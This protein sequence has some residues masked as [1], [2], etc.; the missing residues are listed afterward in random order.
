MT[1]EYSE[2]N[3]IS[4]TEKFLSQSVLKSFMESLRALKSCDQVMPLAEN[5]GIT[6]RCIDSVASRATE[7]SLFGW[8]VSD[9]GPNRNANADV[10]SASS[11]SKQLISWNGIDAAGGR[12]RSKHADSWFEDL[13]VLSLLLFK[14]LISAMKSGDLSLEMVET[15]LMYYVKKY[16]LGI[17]RKNRKP[18]SSNSPATSPRLSSAADPS[19]L[20]VISAENDASKFIT[21]DS[22]EGSVKLRFG[23]MG[24]VA[25]QS[26]G[27]GIV[28]NI[29]AM[30]RCSE[31]RLHPCK[32]LNS[33]SKFI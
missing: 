16:I 30:R 24:R 19:G 5:L 7:P 14:R 26:L 4:K 2:D 6:Q 27:P 29:G 8:P 23:E 10:A 1:E 11:A 13:V 28:L 12:R 18:S 32:F 20:S 9:G 25:E 33:S 21:A 17:S 3:L 15:C 22:N 31:A